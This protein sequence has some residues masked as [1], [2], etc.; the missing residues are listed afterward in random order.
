MTKR[1]MPALFATLLLVAG[2]A[3]AQVDDR[4]RELL[5]GLV[6]EAQ[7]SEITTLDQTMTMTVYQGGEEIVT[8]TRMVIDYAGRRAAAVNEVMGMSVTM[9]YKDGAMTM[10]MGGMTMP[11]PE[12]MGSVFDGAFEQPGAANILDDPEAVATYDGQVEYGGVLSGQQVTYTGDF[13]VPGLGVEATTVHFVFD[14]GG[15]LIGQRIPTEGMDMLFVFTG[16]P[17]LAGS[18][19]Y[20][21]EMY[22]LSG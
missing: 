11:V 4:A 12:G 14:D 9:V 22:E 19:F 5:E 8:T 6:N 2:L 16:E 20:D 15:R 1:T 10:T 17:K 13:G 3:F 21:G 18:A 7:F